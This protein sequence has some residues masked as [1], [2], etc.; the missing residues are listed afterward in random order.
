MMP[1]ARRVDRSCAVG[2]YTTIYLRQP[3]QHRSL[4]AIAMWIKTL[5]RSVVGPSR[6]ALP[7]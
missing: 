1:V 4:A 3:E 5:H 6:A 2:Q 7:R